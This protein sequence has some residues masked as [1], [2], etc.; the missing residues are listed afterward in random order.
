ME[1]IPTQTTE[2]VTQLLANIKEKEIAIRE[3]N[4]II[5]EH[6]KKLKEYKKQLWDTCQHRWERDFF[7]SFD[8]HCKYSC[9]ICGLW[10]DRQIYHN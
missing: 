5:E 4:R 6:N 1:D 9:C 8:D 10:R 3:N 7:T 2:K